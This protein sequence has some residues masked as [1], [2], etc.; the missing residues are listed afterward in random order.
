MLMRALD[1]NCVPLTDWFVSGEKGR[2]LRGGHMTYCEIILTKPRVSKSGIH[3]PAGYRTTTRINT[4]DNLTV[5][6][7]YDV[8]FAEPEFM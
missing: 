4:T 6:S 8:V 1:E 2:V 5:H 3:Y 7:Y